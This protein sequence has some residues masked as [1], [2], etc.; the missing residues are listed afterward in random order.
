MLHRN[1]ILVAL[2]LLGGAAQAAPPPPA[3]EDMLADAKRVF[4][5]QRD[6]AVLKKMV[7][8]A[9]PRFTSR[10]TAT[11]LVP[12]VWQDVD[13]IY[14]GKRFGQLERQTM[15]L[16]YERNLGGWS[17]VGYSWGEKETMRAGN[18]P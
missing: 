4:G 12:E 6:N 17:M 3:W 16:H 14:Q 1:K 8:A 5:R 18:M 13:C 9:D 10:R 7:R 15:T 2:L 11:E